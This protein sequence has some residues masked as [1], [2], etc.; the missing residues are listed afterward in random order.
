MALMS[1]N[2][3]W[4]VPREG[5]GAEVQPYGLFRVANGPV[6]LPEKAIVGGLEFETPYCDLPDG[7]AI[8]CAP[9]SKAG[10]LVG[11]WTT[12]NG[13]P[14]SVLA[15]SV[16]G[17]GT[18]ASSPERTREVVLAKLDGGEQ[19]RV[20]D[21]FS[22]GTVGQ[23]R[24][25]A[26]GGATALAASANMVIAFGALEGAF[27]AVYGLPGTIH[28][29]LVASAM[30]KAMHL[31]EQDRAGIWRTV[32]GHSVSF[33]NYAGLAPGGAAPAAG[34]TNIYITAPVTVWRNP[35]VFLSPWDTSVDKPANQIRRFAER[36]Y[37]VTYECAAFA[38]DVDFTVCC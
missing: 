11:G 33:G 8:A 15:G 18:N 14:F 32:S 3:R 31:V 20:E 22:R 24:S 26:L 30:V 34:H 4:T 12:V 17:F 16:C 35:K 28:V 5:P 37:V 7:Y 1:T 10:S 36:E 19:R 27:G 9:G 21:I 13:D 6:D 25:L 29:P 23:A 2:A 38:T